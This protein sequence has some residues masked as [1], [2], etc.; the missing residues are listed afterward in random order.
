MCFSGLILSEQ[1]HLF[2][3]GI[4]CSSKLAGNYEK[5][6]PSRRACAEKSAVILV[7]EVASRGGVMGTGTTDEGKVRS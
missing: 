5:L 6:F 3:S 4:S 7:C 1:F 2:S